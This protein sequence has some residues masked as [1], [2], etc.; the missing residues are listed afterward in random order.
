MKIDKIS[1]LVL[2][3]FLSSSSSMGQ[4]IIEQRHLRP[5]RIQQIKIKKEDSVFL[6]K[7]WSLLLKNIQLKNDVYI[8][9]SSLAKIEIVS[10]RDDL[11]YQG[12]RRIIS[13][14]SFFSLLRR[15]FCDSV[16]FKTIAKP[17]YEMFA[18]IDPDNDALNVPNRPIS[19]I[20][21]YQIVINNIRKYGDHKNMD[22]YGFTFIKVHREFKFSGLSFE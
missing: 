18:F 19:K 15:Q 22:F 21:F 7:D 20:T 17:E 6:R 16:F 4:Q 13:S 10:F 8:K 12:V 5:Y 9:G 11:C 14:D 1:V 3:I 2:W